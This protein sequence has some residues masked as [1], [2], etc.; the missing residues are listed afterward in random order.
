MHI[1]TKMALMFFILISQA[2]AAG[3]SVSHIF[4]AGDLIKA[5]EVNANFQELADRIGKVS[6]SPGETVYESKNYRPENAISQ[7]KYKVTADEFGWG[8]FDTEIHSISHSNTLTVVLR[9]RLNGGESGSATQC[10]KLTYEQ[11]SDW[12]ILSKREDLTEDCSVVRTTY[13]LSDFTVMSGSMI[14]GKSIGGGFEAQIQKTASTVMFGNNVFTVL[15]T[16]D[17]ALSVNGAQT[18]Y[19][20]CLKIYRQTQFRY[21]GGDYQHTA[22]YCPGIGMTKM[23]ETKTSNGLVISRKRELYAV[24]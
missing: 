15:G 11:G 23:I 17:L 8:G 20:A 13:D 3:D 7:R 19:K 5:D 4:R 21:W 2:N 12:F 14:K 1:K 6:V 9:K 10:H 22:W 24:N 16:E 18:V